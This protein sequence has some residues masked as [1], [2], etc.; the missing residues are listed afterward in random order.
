VVYAE[1]YAA[2]FIPAPDPQLSVIAPRSSHF[3]TAPK[4]MRRTS[5]WAKSYDCAMILMDAQQV[6]ES[7]CGLQERRIQP[8][9]EWT[10]DD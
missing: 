7:D 3:I 4:Y 5:R 9:A 2:S 1:G 8:V 10:D 6:R